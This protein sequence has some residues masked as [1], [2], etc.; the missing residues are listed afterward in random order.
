MPPQQKKRKKPKPKQNNRRQTLQGK[1]LQN[2][3]TEQCTAIVK[4]RDKPKNHPQDK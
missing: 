3:I 2:K 1:K 4:N